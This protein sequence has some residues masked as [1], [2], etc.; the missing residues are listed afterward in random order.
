MEA[1]VGGR[2]RGVETAGETWEVGKEHGWWRG[3]RP[4]N[5]WCE[6]VAG[7]ADAGRVCPARRAAP[8]A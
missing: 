8:E 1:Q 6:G 5:E 3:N 7:E 2:G 4:V